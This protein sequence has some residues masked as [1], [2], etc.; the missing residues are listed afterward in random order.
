VRKEEGFVVVMS[1]LSKGSGSS[2]V[3]ALA[4]STIRRRWDVI[5][6]IE[7][8]AAA[9]TVVLDLLVPTL[10]LLA[11]TAGS[12]LARRQGL[13][14]LGL[15]RASGRGLVMKMLAFAVLWSVFQLGVT[16]PVANHL[17]G[18]QQDLSGF[19]GLQGNLGM[20]VGL[21]LLS[22]TL[23]AFGEEVAYRGYLLTR[24]RA[25]AG[26]GRAGLIFGVLASSVLFG[27]GHT[28][29]GLLGVVVVTLDACVWSVL[30]IH[31]RTL[32]APVLAHGFNNT[33]GFITFFLVGP[34]HGLGERSRRPVKHHLAS[35]HRVPGLRGPDAAGRGTRRRPRP[36][37]TVA[38]LATIALAPSEGQLRSSVLAVDGAAL[39]A[40]W[41]NRSRG[42]QKVWGT[43]CAVGT[44]DWGWAG[45]RPLM[46]A[47]VGGPGVALGMGSVR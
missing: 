46:F 39:G 30:R 22:W 12:L 34:V 1:D 43:R 16:M 10:I 8:V 27:L 45:G 28:E 21:L 47:I 44:R 29:Q 40:S 38:L 37:A 41:I 42:R 13:G 5:A 23:A 2:G 7:A 20:L 6:A 9:V 3:H 19:D 36:S 25:A 24:C 18:R 26:G 33:L 14:S 15:V 4:S 35:R 17:S 11:M 32:W 31:Y